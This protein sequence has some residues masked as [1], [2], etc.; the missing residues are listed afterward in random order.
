MAGLDLE[1]ALR[2]LTDLLAR[3]TGQEVAQT[4]IWRVE[5]ALRPLVRELGL[6]GL[7][8]LVERISANDDPSISTRAV[9]AM[10]N[11][12]TSFFRDLVVFQSIEHD[13]FPLL[14]ERARGRSLRIWSAGCSTGMEPYSIAMMLKRMGAIWNGWNISIVATD[15]S[16]LSIEKARRG[17][18]AQMEVQRGLS[19]DDLLRWFEPHGDEWEIAAEIRSMI[20]FQSDDILRPTLTTGPFDLILC[21]NV[22]LYFPGAARIKACASLERQANPGAYLVLGAGETLVGCD[23]A[24]S[25]SSDIRCTY[26]LDTP[27]ALRQAS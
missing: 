5:T 8:E 3:E 13:I 7:P 22:M 1:R 14:R 4:R 18:F 25:L 10:L 21:R 6:S 2:A 9:D 26:R 24:F 27:A 19:V 15:V 23:S 11:H 16:A 17:R 20:Q 12:E